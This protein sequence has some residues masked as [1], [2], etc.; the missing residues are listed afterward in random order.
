MKTSKLSRA[1]A[2]GATALS[3][4][5]I[6]PA[7]SAQTE[8]NGNTQARDEGGFNP[9]WL[10]LLGLA[11]LLGMRRRDHDETQHHGRAAATP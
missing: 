1:L 7:V 6:S 3:L 8:T 10:G 11:G 4:V 9:G 2:I 5:A